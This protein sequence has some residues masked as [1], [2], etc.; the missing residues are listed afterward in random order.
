[1]TRQC[2]HCSSPV[3]ENSH[4]RAVVAGKERDMCCPGCAAVAQLIDEQGLSRFYEFR[5]SPA[6]RPDETK[7]ETFAA[8]D[9]PEVLSSIVETDADGHSARLSCRVDGVTCA[10]CTWLIN[11]ALREVDGVFDVS[12]NPLSANAIVTFDPRVA[13]PSRIL[14][15][16]ARY[17]FAVRPLPH[18]GARAHAASDTGTLRRLAVAGLGFAQVMSLSAALYLGDFKAMSPQFDSF[19]TLASLLI[20]TPVVLYAGQPIFRNALRDIAARH[21]GMDVPVSIAIAAALGASIFNALRGTGAVFFDSATMFVFFL[22]LGRFLEMRAR[23]RAA[24]AYAPG[25]ELVPVSTTRVTNGVTEIVGTI[26]IAP[27]D[28]V[29]VPPGGR[30]PGDG[31]ILSERVS[32]DESLLSGETT[33]RSRL[34]GEIMLG[35]SLNA[36]ANPIEL[37]ITAV[38]GE[39]YAGR[40]GALLE[41]ALAHKPASMRAAEMWASRIATGLLLA[42]ALVGGFWLVIAPQEAF[43][44]V[45]AMLVVTCPCAISLAAPAAFAA[46]LGALARHGLLLRSSDVIERVLAV[47]SWLF[48]KT[49]TV[50]EGAIR[51]ARTQP[52]AE[53]DAQQCI[54]IAAALEAGIDHPLAR[55]FAGSASVARAHDVEYF[56]GQGVAGRV[57]EHRF[58]LGSAAFTNA[59]GDATRDGVWLADEHRIVARFEI[60]DRLRPH[61]RE[62]VRMLAAGGANITLVSGDTTAA[63]ADTAR[64]LG[65]DVCFAEQR[66]EDKLAV[67]RQ[68]RGEA[69]GAVAAVGDGIND[70]PLLA[71]ADVSIAMVS[72]SELARASADIV[73]T[74]DD[75][76]CIAMLPAWAAR[77]RRTIRQNIA[78]AVAYN[79]IGIPLAAA[80]VMPPW[81]AA[82]GMSVSSLVVVLNGLRLGAVKLPWVEHLGT[83]TSP[84]AGLQP[85]AS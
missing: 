58:R 10:A 61:V 25:D 64:E 12:V 18:A 83:R 59:P 8:C 56:L 49:G 66:P 13:R 24:R 68:L 67:L 14:E 1:M 54:K 79:V 15:A 9:R 7:P 73:F 70:A 69:Q 34:R 32:I 42:T 6:V 28:T 76:R 31:A 84:G 5:T 55:A 2:Y 26:E 44:V 82:L 35:G 62:A 29:I 23:Y 27:G 57:G 30:A 37:R 47:R 51:I 38:G 22:T 41:A 3:P 65:I 53:L 33:A 43:E 20:A 52:T 39:S 4:L 48:D 63:V 71:Q 77:V 11:K 74:G 85:E 78:W 80:G 81:L 36:G 75:L 21:I 19:L 60:R 50:T 16:I 45:L 17:G 72:G 40:V 46:G